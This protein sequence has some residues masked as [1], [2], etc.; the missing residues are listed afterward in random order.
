MWPGRWLPRV[1]VPSHSP[2]ERT[3]RMTASGRCRGG[4]G[5]GGGGWEKGVVDLRREGGGGDLRD[6]HVDRA[7]FL[8]PE[9]PAAVED[10][11]LGVAV[12][13]EAPPEAPGRHR[14]GVVGD[15]LGGVA[16]AE[17]GHLGGEL[18]RRHDEAEVVGG[19]EVVVLHAGGARGV[20]GRGGGA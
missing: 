6:G 15:A 11:D 9:V 14:A 10:A 3:S 20:G 18:R 13:V 17:R 1:F 8:E 7:A 5:G 12:V 19:L 2:S 16:D 4:G